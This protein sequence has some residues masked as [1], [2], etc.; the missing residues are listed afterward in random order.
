ML[1]YQYDSHSRCRSYFSWRRISYRFTG[2][3]LANESITRKAGIG[4]QRQK[5]RS[6]VCIRFFA[7]T[8]RPART[9]NRVF[10]A[11]KDCGLPRI[12]SAYLQKYQGGESEE[13][14]ESD[15]VGH[16]GQEHARGNC[17]IDAHAR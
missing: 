11:T 7:D 15:N 3:R 5:S 12:P 8:G 14:E 2:H 4:P 13:G 10:S 1:Y 6:W 17:G 9:Q 16:R